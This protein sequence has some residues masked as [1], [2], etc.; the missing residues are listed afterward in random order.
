MLK[1]SCS[2]PKPSSG[3]FINEIRFRIEREK[4][5]PGLGLEPGPLALRASALSTELSKFD[6]VKLLN[7]R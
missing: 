5:Y 6:I 1:F 7:S 4:F 3:V 2:L